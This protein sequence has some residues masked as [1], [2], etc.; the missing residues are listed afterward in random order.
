[1]TGTIQAEIEV[2][3]SRSIEVEELLEK[4]EK[5]DERR[6]NI[7]QTVTQFDEL[8]SELADL[9]ADY[10]ELR[11]LKALAEEMGVED[12]GNLVTQL[13][14]DI[15]VEL[16]KLRGK[17][18]EDFNGE[19][20]V[21]TIR[22]KVDELGDD[23][24]DVQISIQSAVDARCTELEDELETKQTVLRIPDIGNRDD[25][26]KVA[27]LKRF[28]EACQDGKISEGIADRYRTLMND[29]QEVEISFDAL[30]EDYDLEDESVDELKR[31]LNEGGRTLADVDVQILA[32]LKSLPDFSE[33]MTIQFNEDR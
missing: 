9:H 25:E 26:S 11:Q 12:E 32:D 7:R 14:E 15:T 5:K 4:K 3:E 28:V 8:Q 6:A 19:S 13:T 30:Q 21:K 10:R 20:E 33:R 29:Y 22:D 31:L 17:E 1:M 2:I 23:V 27:D 24:D 18:F 16:S